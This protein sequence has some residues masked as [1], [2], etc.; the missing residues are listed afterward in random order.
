MKKLIAILLVL[1]MAVCALPMSAFADYDTDIDSEI[2]VDYEDNYYFYIMIYGKE[3]KVS[4]G[5]VI[6]YG[7]TGEDVRTAQK[8]L[9]EV[10][11]KG[12]GGWSFLSTDADFG[13]STQNATFAFQGWFNGVRHTYGMAEIGV[14]GIIGTQTWRAFSI[15][16]YPS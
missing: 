14:D 3:H 11:D 2:D 6:S 1:T 4:K 10:S 9:N 8:K 7:S 13:P 5:T 15:L 12:G 16:F